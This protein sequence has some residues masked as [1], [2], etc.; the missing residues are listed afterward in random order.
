MHALTLLRK[1][2]AILP[3]G[4]AVQNWFSAHSQA[5]FL[6]AHHGERWWCQFGENKEETSSNKTNPGMQVRRRRKHG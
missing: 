3:P 2:Q 6:T 4:R 5:T 1:F